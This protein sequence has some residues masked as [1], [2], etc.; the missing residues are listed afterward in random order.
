MVKCINCFNFNCIPT[1]GN[2]IFIFAFN[3]LGISLNEYKIHRDNYKKKILIGLPILSKLEIALESIS[4]ANTIIVFF[5]KKFMNK[6]AINKTITISSNIL[7]Y[8]LIIF[9]LLNAFILVKDFINFDGN[10]FLNSAPKYGSDSFEYTNVNR[11]NDLKKVKDISLEL[12]RSELTG[13][14]YYYIEDSKFSLIN[15][16]Y[17]LVYYNTYNTNEIFGDDIY[18]IILYLLEELLNIFSALNWG[19]VEKKVKN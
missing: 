4:I 17:E 7:K 9:S 13:E 5:T 15:S 2:L 3:V 8:I 6:K 18:Y 14:E 12:H 10:M 19:S 1:T 16:T 11:I